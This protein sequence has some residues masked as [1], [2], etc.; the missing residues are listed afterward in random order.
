[1]NRNLYKQPFTLNNS[2]DYNCPKCNIGLLRIEEDSF[3]EFAELDAKEAQ[4]KHELEPDWIDYIFHCVFECNNHKCASKIVCTGRGSVDFDIDVDEYGEQYQEWNSYYRPLFFHP[5]LKLITIP[6]DTP[7]DIEKILNQSF[8]L[9]FTSPSAAANLIRISIEEI[10]TD[11]GVDI[12]LTDQ[13][14]KKKKIILHNRID[15]L[16]D[17]FSNLKEK[18]F[19]LKWLGNSGS[20]SGEELSLDDAMDAYELAEYVLSEIYYSAPNNLDKLAQEINT[21]KGPKRNRRL[22]N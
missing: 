22:S 20:H 19:A 14:G 8:E 21:S 2:P 13:N 16:P 11:Q 17:K 3:R 12:Y 1:M 9:F 6:K 5:N 10:L 15:N 4:N 18:F 7:S